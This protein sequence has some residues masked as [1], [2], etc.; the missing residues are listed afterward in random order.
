MFNAVQSFLVQVQELNELV[1]I[2]AEQLEG[3]A[4]VVPASMGHKHPAEFRLKQ[5]PCLK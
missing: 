1:E 4:E 2:D 5:L 3:Y